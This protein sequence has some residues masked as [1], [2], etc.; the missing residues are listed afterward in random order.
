LIAEFKATLGSIAE[1]SGG[2]LLCGERDKEIHSITTDSRE[3][4]K[5]SLFVPIVGERFDGHGFIDGLVRSGRIS[6]FLTM[7]DDHDKLARAYHTGAILCEDTMKAYGSI[8][9]HHRSSM[10]A[11]V[12]GITGTNG[13]T[14]TKELLWAILS[15][16]HKTLKNEKNY[17]NEI[18]VP[19][20]LLGLKEEHNWAVIEMGM[21]HIGEIDRLSGIAKP[22]IALITNAGEGHLEFLGTV[23]N[24]ALAKS[25]IMNGMEA[26][27]SVILN[28]DTQ[29]YDLLYKKASDMNMNIKTFGLSD[30]ADVKP[31][32]YKLFA[33]TIRFGYNNEEYAVPLYGIHNIYN[34]LAAMTAALE[35]GV[36]ANI[37][38]DAFKDFKNIDMRSQIVT[39]KNYTVIN[40]TYNSNPLSAGYALKSLAEIFPDKRKIAILSD[41]KELGASSELFHRELGKQIVMYGID[42]LFTWGDMAGNI[43]LGARESGMKNDRALYFKEKSGLI[44][45]IKKNLTL[46]DVILVKGSRSMKMEEVVEAIIH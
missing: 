7:S 30:N 44:D 36:H 22:D 28:R 4:G 46:D 42:M 39:A 31:D 43:A 13:K 20:T 29:C 34:A 37:I 27:S 35:L 9:S 45:H 23:E 1:W 24:V 38:K 12:I 11:K 15:R 6:A 2:V 41:M 19:Y 8:A 3:L 18:G 25:E 40:D 10:K 32:S 16:K 5:D 14:T 17:N 26:G 21:N 33:D